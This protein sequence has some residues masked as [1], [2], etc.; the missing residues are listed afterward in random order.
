MCKHVK[1]SHVKTFCDCLSKTIVISAYD[2]FFG[3]H[4]SVVLYI[5]FYCF[6]W[7]ITAP[8]HIDTWLPGYALIQHETIDDEFDW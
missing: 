3:I 2:S 1:L 8:V 5:I 4:I 6:E 7:P